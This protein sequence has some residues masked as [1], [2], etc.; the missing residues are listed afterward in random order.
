MDASTSSSSCYCT[1]DR[2]VPSAAA[3]AHAHAPGDAAHQAVSEVEDYTCRQEEFLDVRRLQQRQRWRWGC[4]SEQQR[5]VVDDSDIEDYTCR[6]EEFL[7]VRRRR[8]RRRRWGCRSEQ[9]R[10]VV[11]DDSDTDEV[12]VVEEA[13]TRTT[14]SDDDA[15]NDGGDNTQRQQQQNHRQRPRPRPRP[16]PQQTHRPRSRSRTGSTTRPSFPQIRATLST[17]MLV[18]ALSMSTRP[19]PSPS[20]A[21]PSP[22]VFCDAFFFNNN[23][24]NNRPVPSPSFND[25]PPEALPLL[26]EWTYDSQSKQLTGIVNGH[27]VVPDGEII[28]TSG[29]LDGTKLPTKVEENNNNKK[30][31]EENPTKKQNNKKKNLPVVTTI[32]G[33]RYRL[34]RADITAPRILGGGGGGGSGE[35]SSRRQKFKEELQNQ[36]TQNQKQRLSGYFYSTD[37]P[38]DDQLLFLE[39]LT[40]SLRELKQRQL[41][42]QQRV[43]NQQRTTT[44]AATALAVVAGVTYTNPQAATDTLE[45]VKDQT[46]NPNSELRL[47]ASKLQS[48]AKTTTTQIILPYLEEQI[49]RLKQEMGDGN[50][51]G[52]GVSGSTTNVARSSSSS[53]TA[54]VSP[55]TVAATNKDKDSEE[56]E[57]ILKLRAELEK[58][59]AQN[60][61]LE[62]ELKKV[63]ESAASISSSSTSTAATAA[64]TASKSSSTGTLPE[65]ST[66]ATTSPAAT[67]AT[68][69][70]TAKTDGDDGMTSVKELQDQLKAQTAQN[71]ELEK[72]LMVDKED[73][74]KKDD[75][76]V[77]N[78]TPTARV[79]PA[80]STTV[81]NKESR[82][83][84]VPSDA[85]SVAAETA[86][87]ANAKT[88]AKIDDL[89]WMKDEVSKLATTNNKNKQQPGQTPVAPT[90]KSKSTTDSNKGETTISPMAVDAEAVSKKMDDPVAPKTSQ[91]DQQLDESTTALKA[92]GD[93]SKAPVNSPSTTSTLTSTSSTD[94]NKKVDDLA[95]QVGKTSTVTVASDEKKDATV[96]VS[97]KPVME[98]STS[99]PTV[100][101]DPGSL[102]VQQLKSSDPAPTAVDTAMASSAI[103]DTKP[104]T[105]PAKGS[106]AEGTVAP[107]PAPVVVA[108][109]FFEYMEKSLSSTVKNFD[110]T[111]SNSKGTYETLLKASADIAS[112]GKELASKAL[113]NSQQAI[114]IGQQVVRGTT[115]VGQNVVQGATQKGQQVGKVISDTSPILIKSGKQIVKVVGT[116]AKEVS[117]VVSDNAPTIV[118]GVVR[119]GKVVGKT[120]SEK[121][122]LIVESSQQLAKKMS[123]EVSETV[124]DISQDEEKSKRALAAGA[125]VTGAAVV[126]T[127]SAFSS[128]NK[129][130]V[131]EQQEEQGDGYYSNENTEDID[132]ETIN[133]ASGISG[134][135]NGY[136]SLNESTR[137]EPFSGSVSEDVSPA[138]SFSTSPTFSTPN[139]GTSTNLGTSN[140]SKQ[141]SPGPDEPKNDAKKTF[142]AYISNATAAKFPSRTSS[143]T[144]T[145]TL[146]EN[147]SMMAN[148]TDSSFRSPKPLVPLVSTSLTQNKTKSS[149]PPAARMSATN[150]FEAAKPIAKAPPSAST[151]ESKTKET[152][153]VSQM[154]KN[155]ISS[156]PKTPPN[157]FQTSSVGVMNRETGYNKT[158]ESSMPSK[159]PMPNN[160][161]QVPK[162]KKSTPP[163]PKTGSNPFQV[164]KNG[165]S[166]PKTGSNPFQ[167]SSIGLKNGETSSPKDAKLSSTSAKKKTTTNPFQVA[168]NSISPPPKNGSNQFQ[169]PPIGL[170]NGKTLSPNGAG[171]PPTKKTEKPDT[172]P[173]EA[174]KKKSSPSSNTASNPFKVPS[175]DLTK[176]NTPSPKATNNPFQG[177]WNGKNVSAGGFK[178][179]EESTKP[180]NDSPDGP[181]PAPFFSDTSGKKQY[182]SVLGT[183]TGKTDVGYSG[184]KK[185]V[186]FFPD[187]SSGYSGMA[188]KLDGTDDSSGEQKIYEALGVEK[189][190]N[191]KNE[192]QSM[193]NRGI[194]GSQATNMADGAW[195]KET[196]KKLNE[197]AKARSEAEAILA[198]VESGADDGQLSPTEAY[199]AISATVEV[200]ENSPPSKSVSKELEYGV[201][202]S[203]LKKDKPDNTTESRSSSTYSYSALSKNKVPGKNTSNVKPKPKPSASS[204]PTSTPTPPKSKIPRR[205]IVP[206]DKPATS[207]SSRQAVSL[208]DNQ[209]VEE[210]MVDGPSKAQSEWNKQTTFNAR[211]TATRPAS[212]PSEPRSRS[213][214]DM[215]S[216][217]E[218]MVEGPGKSQ[219]EWNKSTSF[220]SQPSQS[221]NQRPQSSPFPSVSGYQSIS[222]GGRRDQTKKPVINPIDIDNV[223]SEVDDALKAAENSL[224]T[225]GEE[226]KKY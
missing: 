148:K 48:E 178:K 101:G 203:F 30:Q 109:N 151:P 41:F 88:E 184:E 168:K 186:P 173:L 98:S 116:S 170:K 76:L 172:K 12:E 91:K 180:K 14:E 115:E 108:P 133:D 209:S 42:E 147:D 134:T 117:K 125:V 27:P 190:S 81:E 143:T 79:P 211:R 33:T 156:P 123:T 66:S 161:V 127:A 6:Q 164:P 223:M 67:A 45:Y 51:D 78:N 188:S 89:T 102:D 13:V 40:T 92:E 49:A 56:N 16:R 19:S 119:T 140:V 114:K 159:I 154:P 169:A 80:A 218:R 100:S 94:A 198:S 21:S 4:R 213:L 9:Q 70:A 31:E 72:H 64:E 162:I 157:P 47:T 82:S 163:A 69:A 204:T 104:D 185:P 60:L 189:D 210:R 150:P 215:K 15:R 135:T 29:L 217:E 207:P 58:Q 153:N 194:F 95:A 53:S 144:G 158:G 132:F 18:A 166:P 99:G 90:S 63:Q 106:G 43:Q 24:N 2:L 175:F 176:G 86:T 71:D 25:I 191:S 212:S 137:I 17:M 112:D 75:V 55:T 37:M 193:E 68:A 32:K 124:Q 141:V 105:S 93:T 216:V 146:N 187:T 11:D 5:S 126:A 165:S 208:T 196:L 83:S 7:D 111:V 10:S 74:N 197:A 226:D 200:T 177:I 199:D 192:I 73:D 110:A 220:N 54:A 61:E 181:G 224:S 107:T 62:K 118:D 225:D 152:T 96:D 160:S 35:A 28:T 138:S 103:K 87:T 139:G 221:R 195:E 214:T 174:P 145:A 121:V 129:K 142:G 205:I 201:L 136:P 52:D 1:A 39:E 128:I 3:H 57:E 23:N 97:G 155:G 44:I 182:N 149:R 206:E 20:P 38:Y 46:L 85:A 8:R 84:P 183:S 222:T 130:Q 34:G 171:T 36:S 120:V 219:S 77:D 50:G 22:I 167:A 179:A 59:A 202:G 113:K 65:P 26:E 131:E 122:P